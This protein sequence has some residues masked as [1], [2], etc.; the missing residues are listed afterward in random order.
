MK[1]IR[2]VFLLFVT[3]FLM[4]VQTNATIPVQLRCNFWE[5]PLGVDVTN[6]VLGWTIKTAS[7]TRAMHQ[8][9]YRILVSTSAEAL[10]NDKGNLWD[11][12]KIISD[13]MGQ[14]V[15]SGL[16]LKSSQ[17]CWWKVKIWDEKGKPSLWSEPSQWTMGVL[18][19][20]DWKA[21]WISAR[22]AEKYAHQYASARL[23]FNL[24]RDLN[25]FRANKPKPDDANYSSMFIRREFSV[26]PQIQ[27]AIIHVCGLGQ[28]ELSINGLKIG[29]YLLSPGWSDY[30]KTVLYD[31]YDVTQQLITGTNT[32]GL[33]LSNGMYNIQPDSVRYVKF[34]NSYGPLKAIVHLLIEYNDGSVQTIGTDNTWQVSPGP[35]TYMN[36]YGGEDYDARLEPDGWNRPDFKTDSRWSAA[37]ECAGPGGELKGLSC[38]APPVKAIEKEEPVREIRINSNTRV[39]DFG[40][41]ASIMPRITIKGVRGSYVRII[42]SELLKP[43]GTVD[44]SSVT[45]DGIRPAW[46]QFTLAT[47]SSRTYFPKFFYQGARYLQVELFA[48]K[49]DTILPVVEKLNG[50]VV[51]TSATAIGTFSCS[52]NLF[53]RIYSLVRWA[54]RSN[55][56]SV[57]TDCPHREKMP[58]LEQYHLN[59]P[60]LRYNYD[61]LTLFGK[62]MNDMANSQLDD[63][64][65]PNIA[66]EFFHAGEEIKD[67]G[68]RNSPEWGSAFIIVPWQQYLFSGDVSLISRYYEKMKKYIA[69][70]DAS[71]TGNIL[72][73]GLGDWYDI[74]PKAPWGSQLTPVA[75]TATAIYFY[76][77]QIMAKMANIIGKTG[78]ANR[79]GQKAEAIRQSFNKEFY[80]PEKGIYST[81]SNTTFAMPLFFNITEPQ[82]RKRLIEKLVADIR[83]RGNS[84]TSGDVGY[85]FLLKVLAEEGYS[86]VIF[87]MNNQSDRP[88]YGYQLKMGATSLTEKW[89]AGVGS[90]GSQNHFMLGQ[91][92]EWFFNDL[93]GIGD[94]ADGAGFRKIIIKPMVVGDLTW[95]KGSYQSVSGKISTEWKL[96][97]GVFTLD[98]LIPANTTASIYIPAKTKSDVTESGKQIKKTYGVKF[99]KMENGCAIYE[100]GSGSY[101]FVAKEKQ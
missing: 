58:W 20:T 63:G 23:D 27:R 26:K 66:P 80:N 21:K 41:N 49:G 69:F 54:Q 71:A 83:K 85:R 72:N 55:L 86:N 6:P 35:V 36:L 90:F 70:L 77:Y 2:I 53:N 12:G 38:A 8:K 100:T 94:D 62:S 88:G 13:R 52:N 68:F 16:Q 74:G 42:P 61:L 15:Y 28:Y 82:N 59:G 19:D 89:D 1:K 32:I 60:S 51:H 78:D 25:E 98:V 95:V 56:V 9:A 65:V 79:F 3:A 93:A 73:F 81:G 99:I 64:F 7:K 11:S 17:A 48:A 4:N 96:V 30:R 92:N 24:K 57:I 44:R 76:D 67:N 39:Y 101:H 40:Q 18:N 5:N 10:K 91:I 46:W 84:F 22:G 37:L 43:D 34:L 33:M 47:E 29:D 31:T 87:D 75:F 14:V 97:K 50:V 45:Q